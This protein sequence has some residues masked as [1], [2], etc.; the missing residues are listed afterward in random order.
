[1]AELQSGAART[2][3]TLVGAVENAEVAE[4]KRAVL[5]ALARL[6]SCRDKSLTLALVLPLVVRQ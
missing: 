4:I 6:T 1:M 2:Q 5:R 3:D